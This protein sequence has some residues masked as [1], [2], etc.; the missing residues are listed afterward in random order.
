MQ[1]FPKGSPL[2]VE[3]SRSILSLKEKDAMVKITEKWLGDAKD[4]PYADGALST[5]QSLNVDSFKGLFLIAGVSSTLALGIFLSTFL[6][7]N[8]YVLESTASRKE[9]L[10][11]LARI[12]S[13]VKDES[14]SSSKE[15][16]S[17]DHGFGVSAASPAVSIPCDQEGMFSQDEGFSTLDITPIQP[18]VP[19]QE[20]NS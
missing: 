12:F 14:L 11:G 13:R 7:E 8:W 18:A 3:V 16:R 4:C 19:Q 2:V 9:K 15:S 17:P 20:A 5:S 1:A 6:Y 10:L